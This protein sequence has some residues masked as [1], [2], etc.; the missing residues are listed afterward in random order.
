MMLPSPFEDHCTLFSPESGVPTTGLRN[1]AP[2]APRTT[3]ERT[4][5]LG[6]EEEED[7]AVDGTRHRCARV[8]AASPAHATCTLACDCAPVH[9]RVM[10]RFPVRFFVLAFLPALAWHRASAQDSTYRRGRAVGDSVASTTLQMGWFAGGLVAGAVAGPFGG[11]WAVSRAGRPVSGDVPLGTAER[12]PEFT[13]GFTD[14]YRRGERSRRREYAFAGSMVGTAALAV[15]IVQM[16]HARDKVGGNGPP[17]DGG[18]NL[19]RIPLLR[20]VIP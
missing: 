17:G 7:L 2:N 19:V 12:D 13:K 11:W 16:A 10:Q 5:G 14:G 20:L 9:Y 8:S 1:S 3:T 6:Q 4:A 15:I 18:P